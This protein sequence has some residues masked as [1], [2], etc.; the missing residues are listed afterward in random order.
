[1]LL[2]LRVLGQAQSTYIV[3]EDASGVFL[4]DQHAAHERVKFE[5]IRAKRE[6]QASESQPLL[7]PQL[8]D[9]TPQRQVVY[10]EGAQW[11]QESGWEIEPFGG[12]S[13]LIRAVPQVLAERAAMSANAAEKALVR[14]LDDMSQTDQGKFRCR[15][16][17]VVG[18]V[19]G[20]DGV[21][22]R[23]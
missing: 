17:A 16:D 19:V 18:E 10:S 13:V 8:V 11:F 1:M 12:G 2:G 20:H 4:I 15:H 5:E 7:S 6:R 3:A 23:S 22:R 9:L 21:S 14:V